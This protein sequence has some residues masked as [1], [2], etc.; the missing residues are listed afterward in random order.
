MRNSFEKNYKINDK[1]IQT[2]DY[3][4]HLGVTYDLKMVVNIQCK[5]IISKSI[6]KFNFLKIICRR[7]NAKTF[8]ILYK[9]FIL[10]LIEYS[11]NCWVS[12]NSQ[13]NDL[14]KVQKKITKYIFF[15]LGKTELNYNQR[16][17]LLDIKSIEF[18]RKFSALKLLYNLKNR[19]DTNFQ[20]WLEYFQF[21][22]TSRNGIFIKTTLR[23]IDKTD[24]FLLNYC[25][26]PFNGLPNFIRNDFTL[27]SIFEFL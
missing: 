12:T 1:V 8:L 16:F 7:V 15:K 11:N 25:I 13:I 3:H 19:P 21:Y 5:E 9:T 10:P 2:V 20:N 22:Q 18:R 6:Q 4:K 17:K 14:E 26:K 24:K 23:R 27:K